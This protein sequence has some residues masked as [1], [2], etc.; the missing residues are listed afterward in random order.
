[1]HLHG[2]DTVTL[3]HLPFGGQYTELEVKRLRMACSACTYSVTQRIPFRDG[4]HH[5]TKAAA[6]CILHSVKN[7]GTL[8]KAALDTGINRNI[9]MEVIRHTSRRAIRTAAR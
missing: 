3:K 4:N 2:S 7:G 8:K 1:M 6:A 9:V 5:I